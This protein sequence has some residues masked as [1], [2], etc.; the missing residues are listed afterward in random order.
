MGDGAKEITAVCTNNSDRNA[1]GYGLI[2]FVTSDIINASDI[3]VITGELSA[4][5]ILTDSI[6]H[7][8]LVT[9]VTESVIGITRLTK[10][11]KGG[12]IYE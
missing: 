6:G 10:I 2:S 4:G 12:D 7:F 3:T 11:S 5:F 8:Y 1:I 9:S